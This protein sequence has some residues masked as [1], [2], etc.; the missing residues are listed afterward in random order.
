MQYLKFNYNCEE[1]YSTATFVPGVPLDM[2][3]KKRSGVKLQ[4]FKNNKIY[5]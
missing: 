4:N 1:V 3:I 2:F 5:F